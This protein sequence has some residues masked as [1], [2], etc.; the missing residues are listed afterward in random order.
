MVAGLIKSRGNAGSLGAAA[1]DRGLGRPQLLLFPFGE[2]NW[3][4][5]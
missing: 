4:N 5:F 1:P 2:G 3:K